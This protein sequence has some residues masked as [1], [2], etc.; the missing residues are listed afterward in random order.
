MSYINELRFTCAS[1]VSHEWVTSHMN[2]SRPTWMSHVPHEWVTS[3]MNESCLTIHSMCVCVCVC[4]CVCVCLSLLACEC[5]HMNEF[6]L[7]FHKTLVQKNPFRCGFS[8]YID[9]DHIAV[10]FT[11]RCC[12]SLEIY[13]QYSRCFLEIYWRYSRCFLESIDHIAV[14]QLIF[15]NIFPHMV[16]T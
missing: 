14:V 11:G 7:N 4:A 6:H 16:N 3:H 15:W 12:G 1:H 10:A 8:G 13:W 9:I 2:E 5:S